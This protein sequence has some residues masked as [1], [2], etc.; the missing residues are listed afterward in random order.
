M[1]E[2]IFHLKESGSTVKSEIIGGLITFLSII[3]I[4]PV[5]S[6]ILS[7]MGMD[8]GG[9]FFATAL[10][11]GVCCL[12]MGFLANYPIALSAGMGMN[13]YLAYNVCGIMGFGWIETMMLLTLNGILFITITATPIRSKIVNGI[14]KALSAAICIGL[15][16]FIAFVG[17]QN[18]GIV[19]DASTLV[20]LGDFSDPGTLL[21][22]C[23]ILMTLA[24]MSFKRFPNIAKMAVPI[25]LV[26]TGIIGVICS[27]ILT[28]IGRADFALDSG[29]PI[30]PWRDA[31]VYWGISG[32]DKVVFWGSL[33][34]ANANLD[35]GGLIADMFANPNTYVA[36]FTLIFV[37]IFDT[38]ATL[39]AAG[40]TCGLVAEDGTIKNGRRVMMVDATGALLAGPIGTS[41]VTSFA[42]SAIGVSLGARTGL[43][44]VV[45][46][47][48]FLLSGF[49]FPIFSIFSYASVYS[50]ALVAVGIMIMANNLPTLAKSDFAALFSGGLTLLMMVLT[51]SLSNGMAIGIIAYVL[52]KIFEGKGKEL[53]WVVYLMAGLFF[54]FFLVGALTNHLS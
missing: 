27:E 23:G 30:G 38:T 4:L 49:A 26:L 39:V 53:S 31:S 35:Y 43:M 37:N 46:G 19:V 15:G 9:I 47:I 7:S 40:N 45:V 12:L 24:L 52:M 18:A 11:S 54:V 29:L 16:G 1:I 44:A 36:V 21:T 3:Y 14:P 32:F 28:G 6:A 5:N 34:P 10:V 8:S 25:G 51:Y 33:D 50:V 42:E 13:A 48:C 2:R 20:T 22:V 41:T 17:L